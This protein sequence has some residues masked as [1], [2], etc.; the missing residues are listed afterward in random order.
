MGSTDSPVST[1]CIIIV[2]SGHGENG[3]DEFNE[4]LRGVS[5]FHFVLNRTSVPP[6]NVHY[7]KITNKNN[8]QYTIWMW[9]HQ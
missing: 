6:L 7:P 3:W 9:T 4:Q 2:P 8:L 1:G 5:T